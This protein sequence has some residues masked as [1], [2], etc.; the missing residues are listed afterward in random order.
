MMVEEHGMLDGYVPGKPPN[1]NAA[2]T[3]AAYELLA[4]R[5]DAKVGDLPGAQQATTSGGNSYE[6][7]PVQPG[8]APSPRVTPWLPD[9]LSGGSCL[10]GLPTPAV[11]KGKVVTTTRVV[12]WPGATW[13]DRKT[14]FLLLEPGLVPDHEVSAATPGG[15]AMVK[16]A[17]PPAD[18]A[19][20]LVSCSTL[21][22]ALET[23]G[24]WPW[25]LV[26]TRFGASRSGGRG[27]GRL[28][29]DADPLPAH[30]PGPRRPAA[31]ES[32]PLRRP[33]RRGP[34]LRVDAGDHHRR[35]VCG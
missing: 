29:L 26:H 25:I 10:Q 24:V 34:S 9:P 21:A 11:V 1:P 18:V 28:G 4:S 33:D 2:P 30:P 13:P 23:L 31:T 5:V 35:R 15:A 6:Y 32:A 3:L 27:P 20:L 19:N 14:I 16:V 12:R 7:L 22:D 8:R 17:L